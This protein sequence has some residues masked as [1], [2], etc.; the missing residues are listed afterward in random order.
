M[1]KMSYLEYMRKR[2]GIVFKKSFRCQ[3]AEKNIHLLDVDTFLKKFIIKLEK[4]GY[5]VSDDF[6]FNV[7]R[8]KYDYAERHHIGKSYNWKYFYSY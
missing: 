6:D 3:D 4:I 1:G 5:K 8:H 2:G 7:I